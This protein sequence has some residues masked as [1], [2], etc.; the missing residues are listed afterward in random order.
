M[1]FICHCVVDM[2]SVSS[3]SVWNLAPV[4][5]HVLSSN[6][7]LKLVNKSP[8]ISLD[9][10]AEEAAAGCL[11]C[12]Y[13]TLHELTAHFCRCTCLYCTLQFVSS[14][15]HCSYQDPVRHGAG[16]WHHCPLFHTLLLFSNWITSGH[17]FVQQLES[18]QFIYLRCIFLSSLWM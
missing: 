10:K 13:Y 5:W 17:D 2:C 11:I 9:R 1:L 14:V 7:K 15:C 18:D 6:S 16:D 3:A 4:T 8:T 12:W